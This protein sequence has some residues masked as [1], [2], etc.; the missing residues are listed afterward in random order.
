MSFGQA[1][2]IIRTGRGREFDPEPMK[3]DNNESVEQ[4]GKTELK[5]TRQ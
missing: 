1:L 2:E 4:T 5:I 3:M